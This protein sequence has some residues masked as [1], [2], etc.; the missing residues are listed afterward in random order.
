MIKWDIVTTKRDSS[1]ALK[2][3]LKILQKSTASQLLRRYY[4][5]ISQ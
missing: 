3:I 4:I 1:M 2:S 5:L